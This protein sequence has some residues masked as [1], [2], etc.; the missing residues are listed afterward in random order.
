M[1]TLFIPEKTQ[2]TPNEKDFSEVLRYLGYKKAATVTEEIS[3]IIE[4]SMDEMLQFISPQAVFD[5]FDL[6]ENTN[7]RIHFADV[8]IISNNLGTNLKECKKV[9][10]LAATIGPRVDLEIKRQ[11]HIEPVKA[12]VMQ[13]V[14]AMYIEKLV[15]FT[16]LE[17]KKAAS[18]I[19]AN[20][21]PRFSPGYGDLS[22][23]IQ[24]DFFRLLPCS[25]IGLSLMDTLIMSPE[26]SVTAFVGIK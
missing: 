3:R 1:P 19:N 21:K 11:Q 4:K 22:L 16:N 17:I 6:V 12:A 20:C 26:K 18:E 14:G 9:A 15:D 23:D 2:F 5:I 8:E 24:K 10:L 7:D 13:S 25:K